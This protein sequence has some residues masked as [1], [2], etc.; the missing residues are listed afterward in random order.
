MPLCF[1][2]VK[3]QHFRRV[4]KDTPPEEIFLCAERS[5]ALSGVISDGII[6][7]LRS[8]KQKRKLKVNPEQLLALKI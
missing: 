5:I 1:V 3:A 7:R 4:E 6:L 2:T 8:V